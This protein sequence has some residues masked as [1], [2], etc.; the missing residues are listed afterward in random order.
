MA[1]INTDKTLRTTMAN[2]VIYGKPDCPWCDRAKELLT[3]KGE[4][5]TYVDISTDLKAKTKILNAGLR[6]V[7]QVYYGDSLIGGHD[8]LAE[9]L[10]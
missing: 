10:N 8:A 6:S 9:A 1:Y 4:E 3:S 2:Y 5:F 7:P